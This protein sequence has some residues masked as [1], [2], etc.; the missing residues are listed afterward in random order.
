LKE[1][2]AQIMNIFGKSLT[3]KMACATVLGLLCGLFFGES[4]AVLEPWANAY[5]LVLK[6]T[7][8]PYLIVAI[9][10][11]VG[12]LSS[13]EGKQILKNGFF[14]IILAWTINIGII[15]AMA[16]LFP[17]AE[18]KPPGELI[19][20]SA[21]PIDFAQLLI[22]DNVFYA[23]TYNAIPAV[24][25][26]SLLLGLSLMNIKEKKPFMS[27]LE[28]GIDTLT[29]ITRWISMITPYGTFII[30][31][32]QAGTIHFTTI[33]QIGTYILLYILGATLITFWIFP[34]IVSMLTPIPALRWIKDLS[35]ILIL[36]YTTNTVIVCLPFIIQLIQK[37]AKAILPRD[38]TATLPTQGVVSIM[39]NLPLASFFIAFFVLFLSTFYQTPLSFVRHVELFMTTFLTGLGAIG[40]G[41]WIN[42]LSFLL[43]SLGLPSEGISLYLSTIPFTAGFQS[44]ISAMEISALCLLIILAYKHT[45]TCRWKPFVIKSLF[46]AAPIVLLIMALSRWNFL[47][48][49]KHT[50]VQLEDLTIRS[51]VKMSLYTQN[52]P[53]PP[54]KPGQE[55]LAR[56]LSTKVLRVGY[57]PF[58]PP[59]CFFNN[60]GELVGYD[61]AFAYQ[62]AEDLEVDLELVP[63]TYGRIHEELEAGFY[64]IGMSGISITEQRLK[65]LCFSSAYI[66]GKFVLLTKEANKK[67]FSKFPLSKDLSIAALK[68]S[69]FEHLA[70]EQ[71]PNNPLILL[72]NYQEQTTNESPVALLW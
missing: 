16:S 19:F 31:A 52:R 55:T 54:R 6:I 2:K 49:I 36:S 70:K 40:I 63:L 33:K 53:A 50:S 9:I 32:H 11:G 72:N 46:T 21:P 59:F 8:I 25:V 37:E 1:T 62:L 22:P 67:L 23:L 69:S 60:Q 3:L 58:I 65:T 42:S 68:G 38:K 10:H 12:Q 51:P 66:Q 48:E 20:S 71:F 64:D 18:G 47:P 56:I 34:R 35:P 13:D 27:M 14:F 57:Y 5:I 30:I 43:E 44:M 4:C 45:V 39:F 41:S 17:H 28:T 24:V 15:Y 26:F 61:I 29:R 7:T